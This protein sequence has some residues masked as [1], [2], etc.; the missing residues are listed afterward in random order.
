MTEPLYEIT[1]T[2]NNNSQLVAVVKW[3]RDNWKVDKKVSLSDMVYIGR[4][5]MNGETWRPEF[6]DLSDGAK[7][8]IITDGDFSDVFHLIVV[9]Q[10]SPEDGYELIKLGASGNTIAAITVCQK[11]LSGQITLSPIG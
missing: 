8:K 7:Y 6:Y 5:I 10:E 11:I 4:C 9:K 2:S 3:I 1:I